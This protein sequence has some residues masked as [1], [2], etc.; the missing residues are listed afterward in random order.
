[1]TKPA[2][3]T[4]EDYVA[5]VQATMQRMVLALAKAYH[6]DAGTP[7]QGADALQNI[8]MDMTDWAVVRLR[9]L[10]DI[11]SMVVLMGFAIGLHLVTAEKHG[12]PLQPK[13]AEGAGKI[14]A[15]AV[16]SAVDAARLSDSKPL[17]QA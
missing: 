15:A 13:M 7:F 4:D 16:Q 3:M 12:I 2:A 11:P 5:M 6:G 14:F 8:A 9:G 10:K 1:M 17:V